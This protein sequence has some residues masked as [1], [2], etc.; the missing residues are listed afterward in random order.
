MV[1]SQQSYNILKAT[2]VNARARL[3]SMA[4]FRE[5][6]GCQEGQ[7]ETP[8]STHSCCSKNWRKTCLA[9]LISVAGMSSCFGKETMFSLLNEVGQV[10]GAGEH[11]D[12]V[13]W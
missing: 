2:S 8:P 12:N 10:Q 4:N 9:P 7:G 3:F 11:C 1:C 13:S 5:M 6:S